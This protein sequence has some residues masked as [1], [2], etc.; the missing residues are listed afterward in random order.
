MRSSDD[1][2]R[3]IPLIWQEL[4]KMD[5]PLIRCGVLI[6]DESQSHIQAWL[7]TPNGQLLGALQK[8]RESNIHT[9][10]SWL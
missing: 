8:D 1:L 6:M 10:L 4:G 2:Q 3:I 5:I 7:F 9:S